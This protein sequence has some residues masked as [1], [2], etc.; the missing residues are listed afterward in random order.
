MRRGVLL[1]VIMLVMGMFGPV[2]AQG[3]FEYRVPVV[4]RNPNSYDLVDFQVKIV[5]TDENFDFSLAKPDGSDVRFVDAEGNSLPYF[6]QEWTATRAVVWVRVPE[7]PANGETTI[8]MLV[9]NPSA[10]SESDPKEVFDF[11]QWDTFEEFTAYPKKVTHYIAETGDVILGGWDA[12]GRGSYAV[13]HPNLPYGK[14][15]IEFRYYFIDS[16]DADSRKYSTPPYYDSGLLFINGKLVWH[17]LFRC[18][19]RRP[20]TV[21]DYFECNI[22]PNPPGAQPLVYDIGNPM[23]R[24]GYYDAR[25]IYEGSISEL[26]FST[27][28]NQQAWDESFAISRVVIRKYADKDP[29]VNVGQ[30]L[31]VT[32][33]FVVHVVPSRTFTLVEGGTAYTGVGSITGTATEP[34][35]T[36]TAEMVGYKDTTFTLTSPWTT[37]ITMTPMTYPHT[38]ILAEPKTATI[39]GAIVESSTITSIPY[40]GV[41]AI[42]A[43]HPYYLPRTVTLTH[44][45]PAPMTYTLSLE[46]KT[47]TATIDVVDYDSGDTITE[48]TSSAPAGPAVFTVSL[49]SYSPEIVSGTFT[50]D[51]STVVTIT[52]T[53]FE[54]PVTLSTYEGMSPV[55]VVGGTTYSPEGGVVTVTVTGREPFEVTVTGEDIY[56]TVVTVE[57]TGVSSLSFE[58]REAVSYGKFT[59][60]VSTPISV[61]KVSA[62][63]VLGLV[64]YAVLAIAVGSMVVGFVRAVGGDKVGARALVRASIGAVLVFLI[65]RLI[66]WIVGG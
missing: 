37:T 10:T 31:L 20:S 46:R 4:I 55:V 39:N 2:S 65:T 47:I 63:R 52:R 33:E 5:L 35:L 29:I 34:T 43:T 40:G 60:P 8:Y 7:I 28:V 30:P 27:G 48:L 11:Y 16:W 1:L 58:P 44:S 17:Q 15:V 18:C 56:G 42:T 25:V 26:K 59:V 23:Y 64:G 6:I 21:P 45:L 53:L 12:F 14:Y 50:D 62:E 57:P 61:V 38:I 13:A 19:G 49:Q 22:S 9:G 3:V 36:F 24:D 41:F 54:V 32:Y 51:F 66:M